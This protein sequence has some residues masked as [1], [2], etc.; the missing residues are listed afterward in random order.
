MR[1]FDKKTVDA[2][3]TIRPS[4]QLRQR[5]ADLEASD[6]LEKPKPQRVLLLQRSAWIAAACIVLVLALTLPALHTPA[7][8]M[9]YLQDQAVGVGDGVAAEQTNARLRTAALAPQED[10]LTIPLS[11]T[12]VSAAALSVSTGTLLCYDAQSGEALDPARAPKGELRLEWTVS[13][14]DPHK[15]ARLYADAQEERLCYLLYYN[16]TENQW[17]ICQDNEKE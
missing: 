10:A 3:K 13:I 2:Y 6:A 4:P 8:T 11:M 16:T 15:T 9:L 5:I 17:M 14:A 12:A 7:E 1:M